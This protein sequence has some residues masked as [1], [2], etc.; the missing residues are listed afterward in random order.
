MCLLAMNPGEA[1]KSQYVQVIRMR[2]TVTYVCN[3]LVY[4]LS[5]CYNF[6]NFTNNIF[7][8]HKL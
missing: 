6:K 8:E 5:G 7:V 3:E 2:N 1:E 4:E